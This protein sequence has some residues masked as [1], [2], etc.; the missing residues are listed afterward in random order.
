MIPVFCIKD[1]N[2]HPIK[3][4]IIRQDVL[5]DIEEALSYNDAHLVS[6]SRPVAVLAINL[7]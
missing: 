7:I 1:F 3:R 6:S 2:I 4:T 5:S